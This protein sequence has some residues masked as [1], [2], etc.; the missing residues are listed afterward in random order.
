MEEYINLLKGIFEEYGLLFIFPLLL[1]E[2]FPFIGFI[3]P[4]VTT[5]L[6]AGFLLV[7][8]ITSL[9]LV[10]LVSYA[11]MVIGDNT[12]F[13]LGRLSNGKWK[14]LNKV[15]ERTPEALDIIKNQSIYILFFYQFAP[16]F[17]MFLPYAFGISN[18]EKNKWFIINLI[19]SF[20]YVTVFITIGFISAN[21][22]KDFGGV[23]LV[24]KQLNTVLITLSIVYGI[25]LIRKIIIA[26]RGRNDKKNA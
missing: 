1:L 22:L 14:W 13:F 3:T 4:A 18:Y 16:Y 11:G 2:N 9:L 15:T 21:I 23:Q 19:G 5:L 25:Y 12:W 6:L 17:R 24:G 8:N 26:R 10:I 20:L 7:N